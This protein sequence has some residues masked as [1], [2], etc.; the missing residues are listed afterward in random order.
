M[1]K[2]RVNISVDRNKLLKAKKKLHLF[3]GKLSTMFD[4]Y[5]DEFVKTMDKEAG[6]D[7]RILNDKLKELEKRMAKLEEK[8]YGVG[9]KY[10]ELRNL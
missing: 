5:L 3:G 1:V 6:G 7:Y 8:K 10:R 9:I 2:I 4:A